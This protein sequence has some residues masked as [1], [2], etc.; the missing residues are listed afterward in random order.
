MLPPEGT[1]ELDDEEPE[2]LEP[3]DAAGIELTGCIAGIGA[4]FCPVALV[5]FTA[6]ICGTGAPEARNLDDFPEDFSAMTHLV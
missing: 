5:G 1:D 2:V 4:P 6:C 3:E